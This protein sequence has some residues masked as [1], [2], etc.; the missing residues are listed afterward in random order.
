MV[1]IAARNAGIPRPAHVAEPRAEYFDTHA[2]V[3]D[4]GDCPDDDI[5]RR[6]WMIEVNGSVSTL[7]ANARRFGSK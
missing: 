7:Y 6:S 5:V 3:I 1:M 4:C 2:L